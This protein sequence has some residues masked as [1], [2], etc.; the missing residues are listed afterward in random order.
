MD[1][2]ENSHAFVNALYFLV[3]ICVT[4]GGIN[5][6]VS[7]ITFI[8]FFLYSVYRDGL[9]CIRR[10]F[11]IFFVIPLSAAVLNPLFNHRGETTLFFMGN[12]PITKESLYYGIVVSVFL[13]A[14]LILF[15]VMRGVL[16]AKKWSVLL[17]RISPKFSLLF[18]MG[19]NMI[20]KLRR[21]YYEIQA[22]QF[23]M[24][25]KRKRGRAVSVLVG[26]GLEDSIDRADSMAA[27]GYMLKGKKTWLSPTFRKRD[28]RF[29]LTLFILAILLFA[30]GGIPRMEFFPSVVFPNSEWKSI[31]FYVTYAVFLN[32]PMIINGWE[33]YRWKKIEKNY[34]TSEI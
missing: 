8:S 25:G 6:V 22:V 11:L 29:M 24:S 31:M 28:L 12:R 32:V 13:M 14:M 1:K 17:G 30:F 10:R 27:R 3:A 23:E 34:F 20:P 19:L 33:G 4:F 18:S 16:T 7:G 2:F 26:A 9:A 21:D 15:D 5:P